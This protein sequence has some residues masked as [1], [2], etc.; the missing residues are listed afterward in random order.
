MATPSAKAV[1]LIG[2]PSKGTRFRPLSL[3]LPKPLFSVGGRPIIWHSLVALSH[4]QELSEVLLIG[5]YD[6]AVINPFIKEAQRDFPNLSIRYLREYQAL[7]TAGGLYHYRDVIL[8]GN[9]DQIFVLH[10]DIV[11][12]WPLAELQKFHASHRG[13]GTVMAVKVPREEAQKFGCIVID[14][15]TSQVRHW[16]E[17]P[18]EFL[19]DEVNAGLYIFDSAQ[20]FSVI[21]DAMDIKLKRAADDPEATNDEQLRLEQDVLSPLAHTGKLFA[22]RSTSPWVQI[23]SAASAIPANALILA[24]YKTTNPSLLRRRSPTILAKSRAD[25]TSKARKGPEIVE[26]CFIHE[27]AEIDD[28]AKIGPNVSIGANVKIGFGARVKE[29]IVLDNA[30]LDKNAVVLYSI[31]GENCKLGPWARVEGA[32]L[33]N[34]KQSIAILGKDVAVLK[35]VHIRSC[36]VLPSKV[37][38]KSAKNEVLL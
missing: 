19:S 6:E 37:L 27:S 17:R 34:D 20:I 23:K 21:R 38:S 36:I 31:I 15:E 33:V 4:V 7:G 28:S 11:C 10:S 13:V 32:P 35:E 18:E 26:P 29:A 14:G 30:T 5:F 25:Y 24:S 16:V 12:D 22:Y 2:G 1:I 8:K 9:P 3:D